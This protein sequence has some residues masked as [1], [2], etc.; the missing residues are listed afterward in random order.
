MCVNFF[1]SRPVTLQNDSAN[2]VRQCSIRSVWEGVE[3]FMVSQRKQTSWLSLR[4]NYTN[5]A[6]TVCRRSDCQLLRIEGAA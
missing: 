3:H 4:E 2:D 5:R 1:I 6:I